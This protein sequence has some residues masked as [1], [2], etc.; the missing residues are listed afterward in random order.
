MRLRRGRRKSVGRL[1]SARFDGREARTVTLSGLARTETL[2][3]V[4]A[5]EAD[6]WAMATEAL[7]GAMEESTADVEAAATAAARSEAAA[8]EAATHWE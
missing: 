6:A 2:T 3:V 5:M 7:E 8:A 1:F 4:G